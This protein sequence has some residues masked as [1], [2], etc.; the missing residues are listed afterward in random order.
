MLASALLH[1][2]IEVQ[3]ETN[4]KWWKTTE[5]ISMERCQKEVIDIWHF[6]IQLSMEAGMQMQMILLIDI[7]K[8]MQKIFRSPKRRVLKKRAINL[9]LIFNKLICLNGSVHLTKKAI[10]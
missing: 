4:W 5:K 7:T 9:C 10:A 3:R 8:N 6:V 2:V 1:E